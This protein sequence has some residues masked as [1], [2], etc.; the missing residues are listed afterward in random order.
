MPK[1]PR[2]LVFFL[3]QLTI[4]WEH[5]FEGKIGIDVYE[6]IRVDRRRGEE[7]TLG[8][9]D[10]LCMLRAMGVSEFEIR[11]AVES[12]NQSPCQRQETLFSAWGFHCG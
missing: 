11:A 10:R 8:W 2:Y 9:M 7:L 3:L 1:L 4:A 6:M 12:A 5:V